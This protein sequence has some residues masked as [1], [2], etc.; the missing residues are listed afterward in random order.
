MPAWQG[1]H[2][3]EDTWALVS[4]IRKMPTL[5]QADLMDEE[6]VGTTRQKPETEHRRRRQK[7]PPRIATIT[8]TG[9][10]DASNLIGARRQ[11]SAAAMP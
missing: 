5:T 8:A 2:T 6:P 7:D 9:R 10:A 1:E 4:F 11:R 3:A